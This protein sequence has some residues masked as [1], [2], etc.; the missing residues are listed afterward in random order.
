MTMRQSI[1]RRRYLAMSGAATLGATFGLPGA[2]DPNARP[3]HG[4]TTRHNDPRDPAAAQAPILPHRAACD[5]GH[6]RNNGAWP[7]TCG[8]DPVVA[9]LSPCVARE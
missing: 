3:E 6:V 1:S 7:A 5:K 4:A 9:D 2:L 8:P